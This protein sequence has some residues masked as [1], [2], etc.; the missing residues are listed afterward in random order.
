[1]SRFILSAIWQTS[2]KDRGWSSLLH[3]RG[4]NNMSAEQLE[5]EHI[6][7][8]FFVQ[9][10]PATLVRHLLWY[11][12]TYI[13][14][15]NAGLNCIAMNI[16]ASIYIWNLK[17]ILPNMTSKQIHEW[18]S[19]KS[20]KARKY[21]PQNLPSSPDPVFWV[22][23]QQFRRWGVYN[24]WQTTILVDFPSFGS[25]SWLDEVILRLSSGTYNLHR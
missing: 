1:M 17:L 16:E 11:K 3:Q 7:E 22:I 14:M 18:P 21:H 6:R 25:K 10:Y 5:K 2:P 23:P 20:W 15:V 8:R 13:D 19:L 4:K 24:L 9:I 12:L